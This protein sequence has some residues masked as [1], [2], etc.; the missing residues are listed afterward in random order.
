MRR[1]HVLASGA[2]AVGMTLGAAP[3]ASAADTVF[4]GSTSAREAI[5][6][7]ADK[8]GKKLSSAVIAWT[9]RCGDGSS[10]PLSTE[11]RPSSASPGFAPA[12]TD[13]LMARNRKGRFSGTQLLG[14]DLGD[15]S[16]GVKVDLT[17]RLRPK[18]ASG[19][20]SAE[21]TVTENA[22]GNVQ[23]TCRTG[24][25]RWKATRAPGRVFAGRPRR[26]SRWWRRST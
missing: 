11:V 5:V 20:L 15:A 23:T 8:A 4:G 18:S 24:T 21:V 17:G 19:T 25:L 2:A 22:T 12:V 6:I 9:A 16:A 1:T 7:K 3:A 14:S 10:F 26:R 13:L